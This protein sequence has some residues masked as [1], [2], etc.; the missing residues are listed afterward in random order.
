MLFR[1]FQKKDAKGNPIPG[2]YDWAKIAG[3]GT[4]AAGILGAGKKESGGWQGT[5]PTYTASREQIKYDDTNRRP[6]SAGRQ[7]FTDVN[8]SGASTTPQAQGILAAYQAAQPPADKWAAGSATPALAMPWVK[9]T[10]T[11]PIAATPTA[12]TNNAFMTPEEKMASLQEPVKAAT[13]RYLQGPTEI[14]RAHV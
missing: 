7:Y 1:S 5:I 12:P 11:A 9:P 2:E 4:A 13:G 10:A 3:F 8:Y 6:G 14:G